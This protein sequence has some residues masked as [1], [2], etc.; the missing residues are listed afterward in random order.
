MGVH[1]LLEL[2]VLYSSGKDPKLKLLYHMVVQFVSVEG[3][4]FSF[5]L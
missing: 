4:S 5:P 3:L 2:V 1:D